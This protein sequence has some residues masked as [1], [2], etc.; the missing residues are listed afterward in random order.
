MFLKDILMK[1]KT[2]NTTEEIDDSCGSS[3]FLSL[4]DKRSVRIIQEA[5]QKH[6]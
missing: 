6:G 4:G 2:A 5:G 3:N 1:A